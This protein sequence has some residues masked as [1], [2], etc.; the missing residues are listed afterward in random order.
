M[1]LADASQRW[2]NDYA[3]LP[4]V[5]R[6]ISSVERMAPSGSWSEYFPDMNYIFPDV[7]QRQEINVWI[8]DALTA[9]GIMNT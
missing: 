1:Y 9:L 3:T 8:D 2:Q 6:N 7:V 4:S 5:H